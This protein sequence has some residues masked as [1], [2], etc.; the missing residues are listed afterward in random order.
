MDSARDRATPFWWLYFLRARSNALPSTRPR[1]SEMLA[2]DQTDCLN[3]QSVDKIATVIF[4]SNQ[5]IRL[6]PVAA[7]RDVESIVKH[8]RRWHSFLNGRWPCGC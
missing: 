6:E 5:T 4:T 3:V 1:Y 2:F 8:H 7:R